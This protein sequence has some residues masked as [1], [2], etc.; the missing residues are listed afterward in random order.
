MYLNIYIDSPLPAPA[1]KPY[2]LA[3]CLYSPFSK[4]EKRGCSVDCHL[5]V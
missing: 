1:I 2:I 4:G 5:Q 3:F